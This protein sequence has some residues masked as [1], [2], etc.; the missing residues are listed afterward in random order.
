MARGGIPGQR[1]WLLAATALVV[2]L[3]HG[4]A[5]AAPEDVEVSWIARQLQPAYNP[6]LVV[7]GGKYLSALKRTTFRKGKG[8]TFWVNHLHLCVGSLG[9]LED[10]RCQPFNP[11]TEPYLECEFDTRVR[12]GKTDT[13]GLGDVKVWVWPGKGAFTIFGRKPEREPGAG[14]YCTSQ[15]VY[16][17]WLV[18]V[19]AEPSAGD[20]RL[21]APLR[22][23]IAGGYEYP[24]EATFVME[25]NWMPWVYKHANGTE[26]LHVTHMVNPHRILDCGPSGACHVVAET[27]GRPELFA[28]FGNHEPHGGPPVVHVDG[29]LTKDG[30]P[31]YMGIM[32]H[33]EILSGSAVQALYGK[34][35][36]GG[37]GGGGKKKSKGLKDKKIKL[38]RHFVYKFQPEPPFAIT[39]ISDE[40]NLTFYRH[41]KHISKR[42]IIYVAGFHMTEDGVVRIS[43][44]SGDRA[45]RVMTLPLSDLEATF[46]GKIAFLQHDGLVANANGT[47]TAAAAGG[48]GR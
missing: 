8:K 46:T 44:G 27:Q 24:K 13:T 36:D 45:A 42:F 16:D 14:Q 38:Y 26:A 5:T 18:Q 22:L 29:K 21:A 4:R 6:S 41:D 43:Y 20:W 39:E 32:H 17:Q 40:L 3:L 10:L 25:K 2:T 11:W 47:T 23:R 30:K 9:K 37:G 15:V 34:G 48:G 35:A 7:Y 1:S 28:R 33:I 31:Y 12:G 19:R